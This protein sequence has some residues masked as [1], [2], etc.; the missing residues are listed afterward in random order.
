MERVILIIKL[1]LRIR[2]VIIIFQIYIQKII[3]VIKLRAKELVSLKYKLTK[4][5]IV[6]S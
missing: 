3:L 5:K 6:K 2:L 1:R 4:V